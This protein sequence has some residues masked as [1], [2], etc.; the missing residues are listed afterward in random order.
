MGAQQTYQVAMEACTQWL[1]NAEEKIA[2]CRD[3]SGDRQELDTKLQVVK[4]GH[5]VCIIYC[6][7]IVYKKNTI[8]I[9]G[10]QRKLQI[11]E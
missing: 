10:T 4:V 11:K 5:T 7:Y 3:T 9:V 6:W 8:Y 1:D 2:A